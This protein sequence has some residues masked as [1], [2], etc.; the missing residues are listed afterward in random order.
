MS[1]MWRNQ[2]PTNWTI[3][4]FVE[5]DGLW[6]LPQPPVLYF[7]FG[8]DAATLQSSYLIDDNTV[9]EPY[10]AD[11]PTD[12]TLLAAITQSKTG[13]NPHF[14]V[15]N[16]GR[17]YWAV[18]TTDPTVSFAFGPSTKTRVIS[19]LVNGSATIQTL[20]DEGQPF[21]E[22]ESRSSQSPGFKL[23]DGN[24]EEVVEGELFALQ[25]MTG[26]DDIH[27]PEDDNRPN[28]MF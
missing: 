27:G 7:V 21:V 22:A 3:T 25:I 26:H 5:M 8:R 13:C 4:K 12:T 6:Q 15:V 20:I 24:G 19:R 14:F 23:R 1:W 2:L 17:E 10:E 9:Y 28:N 11:M 16:C 18:N